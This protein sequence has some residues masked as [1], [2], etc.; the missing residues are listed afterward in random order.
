M[1]KHARDPEVS[2]LSTLPV[3]KKGNKEQP[4]ERI[5][6]AVKDNA[7]LK[8]D[9]ADSSQAILTVEEAKLYDRQIR[10]WG[11]EA[12]Q[13]MR[14]ARILVAGCTGLANEVLKNIVLAGVGSV[15]I[16]DS[17]LV[18]ARDLGA[19]F[20]LRESD[21]GNNR[22][23]SVLPRVQQ[24][25]PRVEVKTETRPLETLPESFLAN[26]DIISVIG[27]SPNTIVSQG[28]DV[29]HETIS[30]SNTCDTMKLSAN[31]VLLWLH[32]AD[33]YQQDKLNSIAR[34]NNIAFWS[35]SVFGT[36][37]YVFS[38]LQEH[39]YTV[40]SHIQGQKELQHIPSSLSFCSFKDMLATV[41]NNPKIDKRWKRKAHPLY[42]AI[43][44]VWGYQ[45]KYQKYPDVNNEADMKLLTDMKEDLMIKLECDPI[46]VDAELLKDVARMFLVEFPATCA[47]LGGMLA[48]ELL[49]VL[50][51]NESP[52]QNMLIYDSWE[53][54]AQVMQVSPASP[55]SISQK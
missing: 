16:A 3:E 11:M 30:S 55:S 26:F 7:S 12:Q 9:L 21:I 20:F 28:L 32:L 25:N 41:F 50:S 23:E 8:V 4:Q 22:A 45:I 39:N 5:V 46:F 44:V 13:R 40:L 47:V 54:V 36:C 14:N 18:E 15:T 2:T 24:L 49:K 19:Q 1:P 37:G 10:L 48:Q 35:A 6:E 43:R 38:D 27:A 33:L 51:R 31:A 53:A 42:F 17:Q 34:A 52:I 29:D